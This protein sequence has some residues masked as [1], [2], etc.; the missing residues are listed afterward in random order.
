MFTAD[1]CVAFVMGMLTSLTVFLV[2]YLVA[3]VMGKGKK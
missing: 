1:M 3:L 2:C